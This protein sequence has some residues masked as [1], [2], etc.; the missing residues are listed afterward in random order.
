MEEDD[1]Q[2]KP[3]IINKK[4]YDRERIEKPEQAWAWPLLDDDES[5]TV[6]HR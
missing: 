5:H 6:E 3:W 4:G 2:K 1:C